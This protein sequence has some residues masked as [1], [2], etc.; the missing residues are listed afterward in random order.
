MTEHAAF[1]LPTVAIVLIG[2]RLIDGLTQDKNIPYIINYLKLI[3]HKLTEIRIIPD[4]R[5]VITQTVKSLKHNDFVITLGGIGPRNN[6]VTAEAIADVFNVEV[7]YDNSIL[8]L[9][10]KYPEGMSD[11][12]KRMALVPAGAR[13]LENKLAEVPGFNIDNV[14][15]IAGTP[16]IMQ[17][18]LDSVFNFMNIEILIVD[19]DEK[20]KSNLDTISKISNEVIVSYY[21]PRQSHFW[22]TQVFIRS[23]NFIQLQNIKKIIQKII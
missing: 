10:E 22:P 16:M 9:L 2:D 11:R 6:A 19:N 4:D 23:V 3:N 8:E 7:I 21:V 12:R 13:L 15:S 1:L 20:L 17:S 5:T 14:Y 18:M